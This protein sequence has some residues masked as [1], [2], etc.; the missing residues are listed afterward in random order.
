M[1]AVI[2][3]PSFSDKADDDDDATSNAA[4]TT[5]T[6]KRRR[7]L[8]EEGPN[9][10]N[11]WPQQPKIKSRRA[12]REAYLRVAGLLQTTT[13]NNQEKASSLFH[14]ESPEMRFG[15]LLGGTDQR[16]RHEAVLRLEAYLKN[17][18]SINDDTTTTNNNGGGGG[19]LSELDLLKLWKGLWH[20]LYLC[21]K[22]PVQEELS[23]RLARLVWCVAGTEEEDE[24]A[25]QV[26][27]DMCSDDE[28]DDDEQKEE[29]VDMEEEDTENAGQS[30]TSEKD[31][32]RS[33]DEQSSSEG[34]YSE[35]DAAAEQEEEEDNLNVKHCRGAHLAALF[36]K[37]F[38]R[39]IQREWGNMDK[40]RIDKFYTLIRL[41]MEQVYLYMAKRYWNRG[42]IYLFNDTIRDEV[43]YQVP[44]GL[45]YHLIDICIDELA[46]AN[47]KA[48]MPLREPTFLDAIDPYFAVLQ[49]VDDQLVHARA[50][51]NIL[52]K[53]LNEYSFV[54]ETAVQSRRQDE[55]ATV[56][57]GADLIFNDVHVG[58]V[59]KFIFEVASDVDTQDRYRKALYDMHKTY[60][61]RLKSVGEDVSLAEDSGQDIDV[62]DDDENN[63]REGYVESRGGN[64]KHHDVESAEDCNGNQA[65]GGPL[66]K[67]PG[68]SKKKK[69][70]HEPGQG[71]S[72]ATTSPAEDPA[73]NETKKSK[74]NHDTPAPS[75]TAV[76]S[77]K[78]S[79]AT[80]RAIDD[81][82]DNEE[83]VVTISVAEQKDA[84]A[85][86]EKRR[87]KEE[88]KAK[89]EQAKKRL[90]STPK[91]TFKGDSPTSEEKRVKFGKLNFSKSHKASM[92]ALKTVEPPSTAERSP[93]T[94]ILRSK[95]TSK[96]KE[97]KKKNSEKRRKKA[98]DY[99]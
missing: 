30:S 89:K 33:S 19:G 85:K 82:E 58:T 10:A 55:A 61:K 31:Q 69:R 37:T 60:M 12:R 14:E 78:L 72:S 98:T 40:H 43:L 20:A 8:L 96:K 71:D 15:R 49:N 74:H 27:L 23:K 57:G 18:C 38:F 22:V 53:F 13:N 9:P 81:G 3:P 77:K 29:R 32:G 36:V 83:Q 59:A 70:K 6:T 80:D 56:E 5:T 26:Y 4:G 35:D 34:N 41:M 91:N 16:V 79:H 68:K 94:G 47:S 21:D 39:T 67:S 62:D 7:R 75:E 25:A 44:N 45:R 65:D 46:K 97:P 93:S 87:L 73:T 95:I 24:Y 1:T 42:I 84:V 48:A 63:N 28:S 90:M 54:S 64:S 50:L 99:F 88:R 92:K 66:T 76:S 86:A 2:Q 52:G 51:E 11:T 17:R